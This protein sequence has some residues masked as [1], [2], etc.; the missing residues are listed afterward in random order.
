MRLY[1]TRFTVAWAHCDSAGIV[2]YP[3]FAVW[4][5]QG[6]EA[7]FRA[8]AMGYPELARDYGVTG[9]PLVETGTTYR[10]P[11]HLGVE[12]EQES[13]VEE[14]GTRAFLVRHRI[15]LPDGEVAAEGFER[16]CLMVRDPDAPRGI[17]AIVFPEDAKKRF[18]D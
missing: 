12:I 7:L 4:F 11:C 16:R 15:T 17:R 18:V 6:T 3:N 13:W 5:D 14:W 9:M 1:R 8:N 10:W 2:F